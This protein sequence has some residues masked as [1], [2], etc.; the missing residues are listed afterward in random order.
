VIQAVRHR[1][2]W[3][4]ELPDLALACASGARPTRG[5][6]ER[7]AWLLAKIYRH[8]ILVRTEGRHPKI[9]RTVVLTLKDGKV[10]A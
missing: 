1:R 8:V 2:W 4:P 5:P 7:Q 10:D 6:A 3:V 9:R